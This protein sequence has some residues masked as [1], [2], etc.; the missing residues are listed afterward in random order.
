MYD[1]GELEG[2]SIGLD[3]VLQ[4]TIFTISYHFAAN[5]RRL[6]VIATTIV[7]IIFSRG[8]TL[9]EEQPLTERV[10]VPGYSVSVCSV[11]L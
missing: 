4:A 3:T 1:T 11:G 6:L 2:F 9:Q 8:K 7:I 10:S 5:F